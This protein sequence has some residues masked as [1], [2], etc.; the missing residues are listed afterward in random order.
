MHTPSLQRGNISAAAELTH[1]NDDMAM[2]REGINDLE[3]TNLVVA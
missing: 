3:S 1:K 2:S